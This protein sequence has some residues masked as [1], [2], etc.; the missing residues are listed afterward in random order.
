MIAVLFAVA[1]LFLVGLF[2]YVLITIF[3][4]PNWSKHKTTKEDRESLELLM[5]RVRE[6]RKAL[7]AQA[8]QEEQEQK[9]ENS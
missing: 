8:A 5:E 6:G 7:D 9:P 2:V 4:E 3:S 1:V